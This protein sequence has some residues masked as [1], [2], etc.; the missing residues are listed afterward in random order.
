MRDKIN[1]Q[2]NI[3]LSDYLRKAP[4]PNSKFFKSAKKF[5][6][7]NTLQNFNTG[8]VHLFLVYTWLWPNAQSFEKFV[9]NSSRS[10]SH[11]IRLMLEEDGCTLLLASLCVSNILFFTL[12][13][14]KTF[15]II[16][17]SFLYTF[18]DRAQALLSYYHST[19]FKHF[20]QESYKWLQKQMSY[21]IV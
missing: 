1:Y 5:K 17:C 2:A 9:A 3:G 6:N 16:F 4:F 7:L 8:K 10:W 15:K 19:P 11:D 18:S 14:Q 21:K 13:V 20:L 12:S